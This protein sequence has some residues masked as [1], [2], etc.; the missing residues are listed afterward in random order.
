MDIGDACFD[1]NVGNITISDV[2]E[3]TYAGATRT[4]V[5]ATTSETTY[6]W[7]KATG[8]LVEGESKFSDYTIS[9]IADETNMWQSKLLGPDPT[10]FYAF[11]GA[12]V[13]IVVALAFV[14]EEKKVSSESWRQVAIKLIFPPVIQLLD[15]ER[16]ELFLARNLK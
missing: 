2:E 11:V 10:F 8:I 6:Y 12:T 7:D 5:H 9:T 14:I 4:V 1:Q 3:R 13:V 16:H 15:T